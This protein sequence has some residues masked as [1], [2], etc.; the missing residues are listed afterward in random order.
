M[1]R[2]RHRGRVAVVTGAGS[3]IGQATVLRLTAEGTE[4]VG[5][6]VSE[7]GLDETRRQLAG[8]GQTA[9]LLQA[10]VSDQE[11]V[12]SLVNAAL[13]RH[14]RVDAL[15]NVAGVMDW[16]LPAHEVDDETWSHVFAVN[17]DGP[18]R[19]SR[20]VLPGMLAQGFGVIVNVASEA[21]LRGAAAGFAYTSAKH[22]VVGQSRSIAWAYRDSGIRCN[23]ICPG[24]VATNLGTSATP[25]SQWGVDQL[26]PVLRL[27]GK[28]MPADAI[29]AT[30]SWLFSDE[31]GHI[32]GAVLAADSG[33]LA[34]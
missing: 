27:R 19:M 5:C 33:W 9:H 22:A 2:A 30:I 12:T 34:G 13:D 25:R 7:Q 1:D 3:G 8:A 16:F 18:M 6:D 28:S 21:G 14:G 17:V 32:N 15:A 10:D 4:V 26:R 20:A 24:A 29:A 31:A 11:A 23:A